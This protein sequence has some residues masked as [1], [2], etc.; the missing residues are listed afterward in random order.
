M[1]QARILQTLKFAVLAGAA[2][3]LIYTFTGPGA[4]GPPRL[5]APAERKAMPQIALSDLK[6]APWRLSDHRGEIVLV[7]FWAT[8]VRAL[9]LGDPRPGGSRKTVRS[10]RRVVRGNFNGRATGI[11]R[12][13][14]CLEIRH[15]IPGARTR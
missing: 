11:R 15:P 2:G 14:V 7:N 10:E 9:P 5:T 12:P 3:A 13:A 4:T 8:S 1:K 6:G